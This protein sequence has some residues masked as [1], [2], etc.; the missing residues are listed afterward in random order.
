[1]QISGSH[2]FIEKKEFESGAGSDPDS[3]T[4]FIEQTNVI[5][6][7]TDAHAQ[8]IIDAMMNAVERLERLLDTET[9]MLIEHQPIAFE[10]FNH[11]K[12]HGLLE[13][14]RAMDVMRGLD[15]KRL[16]PYPK[17]PLA[18]LRVKLQ[19]NLTILQTHLDAVGAIAAIISHAIQEHE[20]DGT[21]TQE[22]VNKSK[23]R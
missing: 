2:R 13:L 11:K 10:E 3:L 12:R 1:M 14:S 17:E 8:I 21:Y 16:G 20:S 9:T 5:K 15:R 22:L 6:F 18:R 7:V 23:S 4:S 19:R